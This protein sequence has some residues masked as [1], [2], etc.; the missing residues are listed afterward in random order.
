M[1][2]NNKYYPN[3]KVAYIDPTFVRRLELDENSSSNAI[4]M[5]YF[6]NVYVFKMIVSDCVNVAFPKHAHTI[7]IICKKSPYGFVFEA[8]ITEKLVLINTYLRS[9]FIR[10]IPY[11]QDL[12][13]VNTAGCI[14]QSKLR[15]MSK[16]K[17]LH[18]DCP[19]T[20]RNFSCCP[21]LE[22]LRIETPCPKLEQR[23]FQNL[24]YLTE[25]YLV[26]TNIT[27][28]M[29]QYLPYLDSLYIENCEN[30]DDDVCFYLSKLTMMSIRKQK[31]FTGINL[32][33]MYSLE[34]LIDVDKCVKPQFQYNIEYITEI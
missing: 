14:T 28:D 3:N 5:G 9:D 15:L 32:Y 30:I 7:I 10:K 24:W 1:I 26:N 29:F 18:L 19:N 11:L 17:K 13:I 23:A 27:N 16:L 2:V 6:K 4:V 22:Y 25:L 34:L 31:N 12:K 21:K 20:I 33:C 8:P